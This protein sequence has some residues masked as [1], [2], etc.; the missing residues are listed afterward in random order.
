MCMSF[1]VLFY[2]CD[3]PRVGQDKTGH[4][5]DFCALT[6]TKVTNF[7]H[8]SLYSW[9]KVELDSSVADVSL[10]C[11]HYRVF[12]TYIGLCLLSVYI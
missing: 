10:W 7:Q 8:V 3:R 1:Q 11:N 9:G 6:L 4:L 5:V 12:V 2:C